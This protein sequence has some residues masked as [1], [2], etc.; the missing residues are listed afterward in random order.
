[1]EVSFPED[2]GLSAALKLPLSSPLFA[3]AEEV[4]SQ[5]D[6]RGPLFQWGGASIPVVSAL[7]ETSGAAALLVGWGQAD[8][9]IHSPNESFSVRQFFLAKEWAVR[10]LERL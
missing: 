5:M 6:T 2:S 4:L 8:D 10:I 7:K 1:M 9:R 3:I